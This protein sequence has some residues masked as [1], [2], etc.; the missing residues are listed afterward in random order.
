MQHERYVVQKSI[1]AYKKKSVQSMTPYR[2][3]CAF[4]VFFQQYYDFLLSLL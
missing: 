3:G 4:D 1:T 2:R